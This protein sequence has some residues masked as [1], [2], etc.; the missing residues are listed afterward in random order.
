MPRK[1]SDPDAKP[2]PTRAKAAAAHP[3][4]P[5]PEALMTTPDKEL[6]ETLD[7]LG[8]VV[9]SVSDRVDG[10]TA[11]LG[12]LAEAQARTD[13]DPERVAAATSKAVHDTLLPTMARLVELMEDL[14][15]RKAVLRERLRALT[16]E[17]TRL[18]RW[19]RHVPLA[20]ALGAVLVVVLALA[21]GL[22]RAL[23]REPLSC[24]LIG[25]L[26]MGEETGREACV[27]WVEE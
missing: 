15:G 4:P 17:E 16:A 7:L 5:P 12:R 6:R 26:W 27:F 3:P 11:A 2:L 19:R 25:G 24:R 1:S 14:T 13:P 18:N 22:P 21:F 10:Q 8:M 23:A 9:A 20:W